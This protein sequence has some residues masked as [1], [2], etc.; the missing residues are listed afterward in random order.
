MAGRVR[1]P[2]AAR[3]AAEAS[4]GIGSFDGG[5]ESSIF[6]VADDNVI[7]GEVLVTLR[8]GAPVMASIATTPL[9]PSDQTGV[10]DFG[11][12][13]LDEVLAEL[14]VVSIARLGGPSSSSSM[15]AVMDLQAPSTSLSDSYRIRFAGDFAV[16]D[17]VARLAGTP[18]VVHVEPN[19]YRETCAVPNDP[20]YTQQWGLAKINA[21][22]AWDRT[23]GTASV[24]VAVID[25]GVDL[26]HP[27]LAPLLVPGFDMV[28]LGPTPSPPAGFR[29]EGDFSGRD[30]SPDDEVGHGTHVAG[31][32]ACLSNNAIGVAGV[33]WGCRI[34]PVKVLTRIVNV[35]NPSVVRGTGSSAD[36]AAGIRW[37]ADH[38]AHIINMSLGSSAPTNVERLAIEYAQAKGVLVIAAMGNAGPAAGPS[39]PAAYNNVFAVGAI[40]SAD[41]LAPFSQVGSHIDVVAPGVDILSTVW[42]NGYGTKSGTSDRKSVV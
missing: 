18:D 6:V 4:P 39:Y 29:F 30:P 21:P 28:D 16:D 34:M 25:T 20:S 9:G 7:P 17:V 23:T 22:A 11:M 36:V 5:F 2:S 19:R 27:E 15:R 33:T 38:G 42:D 12:S 1:R 14:D 26:D 40:N 41:Q 37:A 24:V 8:G 13:S 3:T 31:T 32:I 10:L 35:A